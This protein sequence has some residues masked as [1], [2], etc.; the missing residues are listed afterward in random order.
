MYRK[1]TEAASPA[2][3][4]EDPYA[5]QVPI[6]RAIPL[7]GAITS[8]GFHEIVYHPT[9]KLNQW[10]WKDAIEEGKFIAAV[11]KLQPGRHAGPRHVLCDYESLLS[12]KLVRPLYARR[13]VRL[14]HIPSHSPDLNP[15]QSFWGWLRGELRRRDLETFDSRSRLSISLSTSSASR[16]SS[17]QTRL[18]TLP[19]QSSATSRLFV[20]RLSKTKVLCPVSEINQLVLLQLAASGF[21]RW[22]ARRQKSENVIA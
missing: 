6:S 12:A 16:R 10:Q 18:R 2:L 13:N 15:M 19:R 4:G 11:R 5:E 21:Q 20:R 1:V 8:K 22:N 3:A 9:K 7:W 17:A 14:M